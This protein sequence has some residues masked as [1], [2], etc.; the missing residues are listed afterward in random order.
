[1]IFCMQSQSLF[2][3]KNYFLVSI[4]TQRKLILLEVLFI[5]S[6]N[7]VSYILHSFHDE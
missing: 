7:L 3:K 1:M 6:N 2:N 5:A 4:Y